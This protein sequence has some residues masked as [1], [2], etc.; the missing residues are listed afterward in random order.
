VELPE[1]YTRCEAIV[2]W[3]QAFPDGMLAGLRFEDV[4]RTVT[5]AVVAAV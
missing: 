3:T 4:E 5:S 1:R 2:V